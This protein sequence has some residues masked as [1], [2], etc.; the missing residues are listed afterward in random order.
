M[1]TYERPASSSHQPTA[2]ISRVNMLRA[3]VYLRAALGIHDE[4]D[5]AVYFTESFL[6]HVLQ[7]VERC[8]EME[9]K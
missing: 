6:L 3:T 9:M 4:F 2:I 1:G 7:F 8:S 5:S